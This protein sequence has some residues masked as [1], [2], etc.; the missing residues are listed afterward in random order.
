MYLDERPNAISKA[1]KQ[2]I[3]FGNIF[4]NECKERK[5]TIE[6]NGDFNF[7]FALKANSIFP[8]L[9]LSHEFGTVKKN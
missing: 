4:I 6:N 9:K 7:D 3:N 2:E 8:F 1:E 5:I